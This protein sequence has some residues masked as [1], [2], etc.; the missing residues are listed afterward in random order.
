MLQRLQYRKVLRHDMIEFPTLIHIHTHNLLIKRDTSKAHWG[1]RWPCCTMEQLLVDTR[2]FINWPRPL[3][4]HSVCSLRHKKIKH[5]EI[6]ILWSSLHCVV[7]GGPRVHCVITSNPLNFLR[8]N[9][10]SNQY[11]LTD[12]LTG[13]YSMCLHKECV[14][15]FCGLLRPHVVF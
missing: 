5:V 7:E 10:P 1:T 9:M 8:T 2:Y 15:S 4:Y 12:V 13:F 11:T 14:N 6:F 3:N